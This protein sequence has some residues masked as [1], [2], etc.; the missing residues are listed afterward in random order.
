[1]EYA[2]ITRT[3]TA[4]EK[5]IAAQYKI[6]LDQT[7]ARL[8]LVFEKYSTDGVL[9]YGEMAKYN[10]LTSLESDLMGYFNKQNTGVLSSLRTLPRRTLD[11]AFKEYA[12]QFDNKYGIRLSWGMIPEKSIADIVNNPLDKIA[13]NSLSKNQR[14]RITSA[15]AQGFLQGQSYQK[16]ATAIKE[17]YG[18]TA[19]EAFRVA[20][21]EGQRAAVAAQ[22]AVYAQSLALGI[23]T[24]LYWDA[25]IDSRT[26]SNHVQM[27]NVKAK[28]HEGTQQFHY[29]NGSWVTGPMATNLPAAEVINCFPSDNIVF[30]KGI[31][32]AYK[33]YYEGKILLIKTANGSEFTV[34]VNHPIL[35][36]KGWVKA[37]SLT[38]GSDVINL[39]LIDKASISQPKE[40][41]IPRVIAEVYRLCNIMFKAK[42]VGFTNNQFHG[43]AFNS[44]VNIISID[45]QLRNTN[46]TLISEKFK[47]FFFTCS[48]IIKGFLHSLSSF[49]HMIIRVLLSPNCLI[50]FHGKKLPIFT[51]SI[52][53]SDIHGFASVSDSETVFSEKPTDDIAGYPV[54]ICKTFY[55]S[56]GEIG[57]DKIIG[58][59]EKDFSGHVY[60]LQTDSSMYS[61]LG[62]YNNGNS[63]IVHNCRC[64]IREELVEIPDDIKQGIPKTSFTKWEE[65]LKL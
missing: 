28:M 37:S 47:K 14:T 17:V 15:L 52:S 2:R 21:T 10:R 12:Y 31:E 60:N 19:Y 44:D 56:S 63:I 30:A 7:R 5:Y 36:P 11:T 59:F 25:Y 64:R 32:K 43:D 18:K 46:K 22:R 4:Q 24:N 45:S 55:G 53:H 41:D 6:A 16:M 48:D 50:G 42:R 33:R 20:R 27:N 54:G 1:M 8:A 51:G 65:E 3:M 13:H 49:K 23:E 40:N 39:R 58:I 62:K 34:T 35:T 29:L 38:V 57:I 9:T 26:R 61:V